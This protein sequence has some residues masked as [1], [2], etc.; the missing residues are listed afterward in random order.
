M[1]KLVFHPLK[2][3][4][5]ARFEK[6]HET[7]LA[8]PTG[9]RSV[10]RC[11]V[12]RS[13]HQATHQQPETRT[14]MFSGTQLSVLSRCN[15]KKS[16]FLDLLQLCPITVTILC[17]KQDG[18]MLEG[19]TEKRS[20]SPLLPEPS[21]SGWLWFVY[22]EIWPGNSGVKWPIN[23]RLDVCRPLHRS[24]LASLLS[25]QLSSLWRALNLSFSR[26]VM[27]PS[28]PPSIQE[29]RTRGVPFKELL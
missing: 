21:W 3:I 2:Q 23:L 19:F 7:H 26:Q 9:L 6:S 4:S 16:V 28:V 29:Q 24:H 22:P 12:C 11:L 20:V 18:V 5:S 13:G 25:S 10:Q 8:A 27:H 17:W 15:T 1:C 14:Q